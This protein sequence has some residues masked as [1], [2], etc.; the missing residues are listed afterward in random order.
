M[1]APGLIEAFAMVQRGEADAVISNHLFGNFHSA[2]YG[3]VDTASCS[4]PLRCSLRPAPV[5]MQMCWR[6]LTD[7]SRTGAVAPTRPMPR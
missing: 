7:P 1:D 6:P 2:R 4:S 5:A 3:V